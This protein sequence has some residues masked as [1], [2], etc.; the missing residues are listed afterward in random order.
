MF[1]L[2]FSPRP[3]LVSP[4]DS[5]LSIKLVSI[6]SRREGEEAEEKMFFH[7][8]ASILLR[9]FF[10]VVSI[11]RK[12][13]LASR[14]THEW[15]QPSQQQQNHKLFSFRLRFRLLRGLR[16][17]FMMPNKWSK[18]RRCLDECLATH[19]ARAPPTPELNLASSS[20]FFAQWF[21]DDVA[22]RKLPVS[23][24][25]EDKRSYLYWS[26]ADEKLRGV[27]GDDS[28]SASVVMP[29]P[30]EALGEMTKTSFSPGFQ[31]ASINILKLKIY[32]RP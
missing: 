5:C 1:F 13:M 23:S 9:G 3:S 15:H 25:P 7:S 18:R 31:K 26:T 12:N 14:P 30:K 4:T 8:C 16:H 21:P 27:W 6:I 2:A 17:F 20:L 10:S 28:F 22:N 29:L 11:E 19:A 24:S 32:E